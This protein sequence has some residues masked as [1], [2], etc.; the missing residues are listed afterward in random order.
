VGAAAIGAGIA[1]GAYG[2][3]DNC[4]NGYCGGGGYYEPGY[5]DDG[6]ESDGVAYCAQRFRTY[7]VASQTYIG[8]GGR[9]I[10]CP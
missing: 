5:S 7:D 1:Y 4:Y 8:K 9:R 3:Y 6:G 10:S 2:T